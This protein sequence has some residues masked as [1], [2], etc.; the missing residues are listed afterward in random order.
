MDK[1]IAFAGASTDKTCATLYHSSG[2]D[3][4]P[5]CFGEWADHAKTWLSAPTGTYYLSGEQYSNLPEQFVVVVV[6]EAVK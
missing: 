2:I 3:R 4:P 1:M 5:P 6:R